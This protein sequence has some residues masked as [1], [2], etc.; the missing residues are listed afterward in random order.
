MS[1]QAKTNSAEAT[2]R[3]DNLPEAEKVNT[4]DPE[5]NKGATI[6]CA[7][8]QGAN[9]NRRTVANSDNGCCGCK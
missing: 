1:N 7:V 8:K 2:L 9:D 6:A 4:V 5:A 3:A